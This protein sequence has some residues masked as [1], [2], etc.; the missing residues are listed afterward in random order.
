[1]NYSVKLGPYPLGSCMMKYNPSFTGNVIVDPNVGIHPG[2]S[3]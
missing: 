1:M 2:H 3:D